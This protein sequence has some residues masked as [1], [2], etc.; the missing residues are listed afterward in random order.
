L[1][2]SS[3]DS[4]VELNDSGQIASG[5]AIWSAPQLALKMTG[6][7][8]P[9]KDVQVLWKGTGGQTN[10]VQTSAGI[11]G[12]FSDISGNILLRGIGQVATNSWRMVP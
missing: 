5:V 1:L 9:G 8:L 6:I 2:Y 3:V 4:S 7:Q 11:A 10:I 12:G